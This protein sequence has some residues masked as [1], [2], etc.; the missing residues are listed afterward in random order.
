VI[1]KASC[2]CDPDE[3]MA[4]RIPVWTF[5]IIRAPLRWRD[6]R[7]RAPSSPAAAQI[8]PRLIAEA[9]GDFGLAAAPF[10]CAAD[11]EMNRANKH[12]QTSTRPRNEHTKLRADQSRPENLPLDH[13]GRGYHPLQAI[14]RL[15][16]CD[17]FRNCALFA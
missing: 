4:T 3:A 16:N 7:S 10:F 1:S 14:S 15:I 2:P 5:C 13:Y 6:A 8:S 12:E 11:T 9:Q 17:R